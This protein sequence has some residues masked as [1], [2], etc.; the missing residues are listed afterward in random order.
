[1]T[2][3]S[4]APKRGRGRPKKS[5]LGFEVEVNENA[6]SGAELGDDEDSMAVQ[7]T[8]TDAMVIDSGNSGPTEATK[9]PRGRPRKN[10]GAQLPSLQVVI[11][12]QLVCPSFSS[13]LSSTSITTST[14][15]HTHISTAC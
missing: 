1:M 5:S 14:Q 3:L 4:E 12:P 9:R 11:S 8:E 15:K 10:T 2:T 7:E 6:D 13:S